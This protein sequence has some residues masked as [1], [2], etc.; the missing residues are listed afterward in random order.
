MIAGTITESLFKQQSF[1]WLTYMAG[2]RMAGKGEREMGGMC[3]VST[4][5]SPFPF[6]APAVQTIIRCNAQP[7]F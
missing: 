1:I 7:N 4:S 5:R 3:D 6:V 2:A